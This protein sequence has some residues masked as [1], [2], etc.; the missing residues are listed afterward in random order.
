MRAL[1]RACVRHRRITFLAWVAAL[2]VCVMAASAAG[3][4]FSTNF[5]LPE[6]DSQ[7]A[8]E[9]LENEFPQASGDEI[10]VVL[11]AREGTLDDH[12]EDVT[13]VLRDVVAVDGIESAS[14]PLEPNGVIS[15][16]GTIG[17]ATAQLSGRSFD[18]DAETIE[19]LLEIREAEAD[20]AA[21]PVRVE[22]G[23][24]AV[25]NEQQGEGGSAEMIGLLAAIVV[26]LIMF[27]SVVAMGLPVLTAVIALGVALSLVTLL[28]HLMD[29]ADFAPQLAAMIG[30]GV[31]IDYA[32]FIVTRFRAGLRAGLEP[33]EAVMI[34]MDTAG[35]A[36]LFA[37][38][39][40]CVALLGLFAVGI[41]FLY[42]PAVA[43]AL[44]VLVTMFAALTLLPAMLSKVGSRIDRLRVPGTKGSSGEEGRLWSRWS[45]AIQR[46]PWTATLVSLAILIALAIPVL[47]ME[48]GNA[49]AGTDGTDT[50][51]RQAY[52]LLA[53]GFGPGFNGPL[54]VVAD[55]G[56]DPQGG[57]GTIDELRQAVDETE[58]IS[59][60]TPPVASENGQVYVIRAF[61]T[62]GPQEQ[63]TR[64]LVDRIRDETLDPFDAEAGI[65]SHLG[66]EAAITDDFSTYVAGK[67]PLFI[68]VVIVLSA[69]LL[70]VAFRSV[71]VPL[72]AVL[73]NVLS[74]GAAFG[75]V[76]AIF[77]FG[78]GNELIG[79]SDTAPIAAFL[80]VMVFAIV[81]GLSMDYEV[82]LMSRVH[83]EWER[84][85]DASGAVQHGLASTGRVI[86]AAATIM[87][88]V[89]GSFALG[90]DLI[91]K[92]FGVGLAAA[93]AID[94]FLI[95]S[96]LVPAIM[97][98]LGARA[99][100]LPGWLDR[101][102]P[103]VRIESD[104]PTAAVVEASEDPIDEADPPR[105][106]VA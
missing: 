77:Q 57:E 15:E 50:T 21:G 20:D 49:D 85:G 79:I 87:I 24:D 95:R 58:G 76:V 59:A 99:W 67:L 92:L 13:R 101:I 23:G 38:A 102:I 51:T 27:G 43:S 91:I 19:A 66:G 75:L 98:L 2:I 44:A 90:G 30:L 56:G 94:A 45:L 36:V 32:L 37:G 97:E 25:R 78:W 100:W 88:C 103:R 60:T 48:I 33:D 70:L 61:P 1:A 68:G 22:F 62:T 52:D 104:D 83:E 29:T 64:A 8:Q 106:P 84:R 53:E 86:T 10:Q 82:F 35:R 34:A 12:P 17:L 89:F 55:I 96:L 31:G 80:P 69:L 73:M 72:K 74:I 14:S 3:E 63:E 7:Q 41:D 81:F 105:Q 28:T 5:T 9:L 93:I 11:Q 16:D 39:T 54:L 42:G 71:L 40:V 46:R 47:S 6:S 18:V 4:D 26:L 65:E